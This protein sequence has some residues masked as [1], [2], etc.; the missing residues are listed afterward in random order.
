MSFTD[1][2]Q[3]CRKKCEGKII[4]FFAG[5]GV[6]LVLILLVFAFDEFSRTETFCTSCHSMKPMGREYRESIHYSS[7]S[8]VRAR[9]GDCHVSQNIVAALWE[10]FMAAQMVLGE[11]LHDFK[12]PV[13]TEKRR[14]EMAFKAR[15]WF[16]KTGSKTCKKCHVLEAIMGSRAGIGAVHLDDAA[17]KDGNCVECHI[18][19][20][21][22]YV[23]GEKVFKKEAWDRMIEE[24]YGRRPKEQ[25]KKEAAQDEGAG[26][27]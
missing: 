4:P 13:E 16:I 18:N 20:V 25:V 14:P 21:H 17:K 11:V 3:E 24:E 15:R 23:P 2:I 26:Q 1:K 19:L 27:E 6:L 22:R 9:C 10:H 5:A 12:D 8:G 7:R